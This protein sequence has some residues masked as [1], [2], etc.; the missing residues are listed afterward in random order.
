[1]IELCAK[2]LCTGC[3]AC[4]QICN[5]NAIQSR[6]INGFLYPVINPEK[7]VECGR[8]ASVCPILNKMQIVGLSHTVE[9]TCLAVWNK[10][11]D[12]RMK[13][14]SG[15][16]FSAIAEKVLNDG[17]V[18]FGAAWNKDLTL[19]HEGIEDINNLDRLR[20]SKYVQSDTNDTFLSVK[21]FLQE[22]KR[23]LYC[24]TP[25][26]IAGLRYYLGNKDYDKLL[27]LDVLCQGVPSPVLFRK[28]IEEIEGEIGMEVDDCVFRT[29]EY[30]W[31]NGLYCLALHGRRGNK[32]HLLKFFFERNAFYRSFFKEYFMRQSC[33][34]CVFKNDRR[35]YFSDITIADF[36]RIGN[37]VPFSAPHYERGISA[38]VV[39][40]TKGDSFLNSCSDSLEIVERS[41][42]EFATN[43]GL[44]CSSKP[45]NNDEA[46]VY[47][48]NHTWKETQKRY[49]PVTWQVRKFIVKR[50]LFQRKG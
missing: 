31:R 45:E 18:V 1:M 49:F 34:N 33:Y 23:V 37:K 7:C 44:R 32:H 9:E 38:V 50:F 15:G 35:G 6:Y 14:S 26:Q 4:K 5:L 16:V 22:G 20:R 40:T 39:N 48:Q 28:Y 2:D 27:C 36:W 10:K 47:L 21:R 11:D 42:G 30:G 3:M 13:S 24:G 8:C 29:K 43:G 46:L 41:F 12:V 25:C 17:G 19:V